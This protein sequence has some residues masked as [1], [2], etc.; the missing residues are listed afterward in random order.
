M[1]IQF[2]ENIGEGWKKG[3]HFYRLAWF[4]YSHEYTRSMDLSER[5]FRDLMHS[6]I[7]NMTCQLGSRYV[8]WGSSFRKKSHL[9]HAPVLPTDACH[10]AAIQCS[11]TTIIHGIILTLNCNCRLSPCG[12]ISSMSPLKSVLGRIS[13]VSF[14]RKREKKIFCKGKR[15]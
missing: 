4:Q 6:W 9:N 13:F 8:T 12:T 3:F 5:H 10:L 15:Q 14:N 1:K 7:T 2:K 11:F